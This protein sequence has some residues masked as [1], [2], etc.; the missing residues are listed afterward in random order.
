MGRC[1]KNRLR[2]SKRHPDAST[3]QDHIRS[4]MENTA[5]RN[6]SGLISLMLG[7]EFAAEAE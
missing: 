2:W 3:V 6:R 5:S 7:R 4:M 1:I